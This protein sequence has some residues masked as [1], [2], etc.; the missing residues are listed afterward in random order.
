M[1]KYTKT[2]EET[3][4]KHEERIKEYKTNGGRHFTGEG[5]VAEITVDFCTSS[6]DQMAEE[7]INWPSHRRRDDVEVVRAL[8]E[9]IARGRSRQYHLQV[10][11]AT[12]GVARLALQNWKLWL[13]SRPTVTRVT[14]KK[15]MKRNASTKKNKAKKNN[16]KKQTNQ[17]MKINSKKSLKSFSEKKRT[18]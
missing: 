9:A 2:L 3:I 13:V 4:E 15:K 10:M 11:I 5:R 7:R 16:N 6:E 18:R 12:F 17:K 1:K 8:H 14:Q